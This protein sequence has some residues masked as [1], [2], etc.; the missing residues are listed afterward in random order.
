MCLSLM[1]HARPTPTVELKLYIAV[2]AE[3][4]VSFKMSADVE[5]LHQSDIETEAFAVIP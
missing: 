2:A 5:A 1:E 4:M 3:Q